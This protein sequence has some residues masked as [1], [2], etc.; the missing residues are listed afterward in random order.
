MDLHDFSVLKGLKVLVTGGCGYIGSHAV[1]E[2]LKTEVKVVVI[3]TVETGNKANIDPSIAQP[4]LGRELGEGELTLYQGSMGDCQILERVFSEHK[5]DAVI[6]FAAYIQVGE[7]VKQPL[8]YYENNTSTVITLVK[9]LNKFNVKYFIQSSTA[10]VYGEV[11]GDEPI[12]EEHSTIPINPYGQ[13]KLMVEKVLEDSSKAYGLKYTAFRYFNVCGY[14]PSG[15]IGEYKPHETLLIPL[16]IRAAA[17]AYQLKIFGDD[18][19]TKDG[20]CIRDFIDMED[21]IRG[22]LMGLIYL[23]KDESKSVVLNL[24]SSKGYSVKEVIDTV[25]K[26]TGREFHPEIS[27]RREGDPKILL[28]SNQKASQ[29]L[30]WKPVINLENSIRNA[31]NL[32]CRLNGITK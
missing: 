2:L 21:L 26:V 16:A 14:H 20:T 7:S 11:K 28:A 13:S 19:D 3:D 9:Y 15:L 31:W 4:L 29:I 32:Y 17:G 23:M 30:D 6:N 12:T 8:K 10:A 18:Y 25:K 22:H 1:W 27:A 5:I 24:G